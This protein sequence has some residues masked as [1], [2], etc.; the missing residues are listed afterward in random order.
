MTYRYIFGYYKPEQKLENND[1]LEIINNYFL[2]EYPP[3]PS[4][5][6]CLRQKAQETWLSDEPIDWHPYN[7]FPICTKEGVVIPDEF[8]SAN[9][10]IA[11]KREDINYIGEKIIVNAHGDIHFFHEFITKRLQVS[12]N[13]LMNTRAEK[14]RNRYLS[15]RE[16]VLQD[17]LNNRSA[18]DRDTPTQPYLHCIYRSNTFKPPSSDNF[19]IHLCPKPEYN[20]WTL[21]KMIQLSMTNP[22]DDFR[23]TNMKICIPGRFIDIQTN[24][25]L[26]FDINGGA[27]PGIIIYIMFP[28]IL[29]GNPNAYNNACNKYLIDVVKYFKS[30]EDIIGNITEPIKLPFGNVRFN[31][32][33]CYASGTRANKLDILDGTQKDP[34]IIAKY[35]GSE[36]V[37]QLCDTGDIA[38]IEK[39]FMKNI[40]GTPGLNVMQ[41]KEAPLSDPRLIE[42][43]I[44]SSAAAGG[45]GNT[46][47]GARRRKSKRSRKTDRKKYQR[48]KTRK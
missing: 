3:P 5:I 46:F 25:K 29:S 17:T 26:L 19:K 8:L 15:H 43:M 35:N 38:I 47:G 14:T 24:D 48:R 18:A 30:V 11:G 2:F 12:L 45:G 4:V 6:E 39:Y 31:K 20:F 1:D 10:L 13:E 7:C 34:A 28:R 27:S 37:Q 22:I 36:W 42:S 9:I 44:D 32:L 21:F 40:C 16:F 41:L 23:I 33:V